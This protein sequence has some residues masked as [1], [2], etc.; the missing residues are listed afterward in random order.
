MRRC[1]LLLIA[2]LCFSCTA[3]R[4]P[5]PAA[6]E[7][8]APTGSAAPS[9]YVIGPGDRLQI[10]VYAQPDL[11]KEYAV[12]AE[13]DLSM[14]LAGQVHA[15]G[16][17]VVQLEDQLRQRFAEYIK[18][19]QV[20]VAVQQFQQRFSVLGQVQRP[21][22]YAL[23]KRTTTLQAVSIAGGLTDKAAPNRTR[24]IRAAGGREQPIDV[25]LGDI[26]DGTDTNRDVILQ[27]DDKVVVPESFF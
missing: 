27:P 25:P 6:P 2:L 15:A 3:S 17:S 1:P 18:K 16:L 13:G 5:E 26:M 11:S 10:H 24:V 8:A 21:G 9:V 14:P 22:T 19:P 7:H 4:T 20:T 23:D 12:T